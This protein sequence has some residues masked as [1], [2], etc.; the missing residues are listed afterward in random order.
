EA[1]RSKPPLGSGRRRGGRGRWGGGA[2][3]EALEPVVEGVGHVG[4]ARGA[5]QHVRGRDELAVAV[6]VCAPRVEKGSGWTEAD[7]TC[8]AR[9]GH[10]D[11]ALGID[12]KTLGLI[13]ATK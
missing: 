8:V 11:V 2:E 13:Q 6:A 4:V 5:D 10:G 7:H 3:R 9:I 1:W 12:A